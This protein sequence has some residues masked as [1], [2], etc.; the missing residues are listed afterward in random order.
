MNKVIW[1]AVSQPG[2]QVLVLSDRYKRSK[3]MML[4]YM[5]ILVNARH[6][7]KDMT[8]TLTNKSVIRFIHLDNEEKLLGM[9]FDAIS[10]DECVA[11]DYIISKLKK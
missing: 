8:I 10:I 2:S 9:K 3:E 7:F 6:D 5:T 1:V 4:R 11:P